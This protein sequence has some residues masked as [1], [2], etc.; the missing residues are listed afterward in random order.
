M[1]KKTL[2]LLACLGLVLGL[3]ACT[4]PKQEGPD[5]AD[6]EAMEVIASGFE[7]RSD[8]IYAQ[9]LPDGDAGIKKNYT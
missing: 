6:D 3:T 1:Y 4:E 7:K 5:Y 9:D 8:V 2:G